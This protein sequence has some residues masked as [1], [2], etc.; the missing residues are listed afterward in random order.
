MLGLKFR[1]QHV[2]DGFVVDFY[3]AE[4]RVALEIDGAVHDRREV[5]EYD[6]ARTEWLKG[7]AIRVVR[8]RNDQVN[9]Q[10]LHI[11]LRDLVS[12]PSP[13]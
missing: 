7:R 8:I 3:C 12:S 11:L 5:V 9:Q 10:Q 2:I 4:L 1:R 13:H 6:A